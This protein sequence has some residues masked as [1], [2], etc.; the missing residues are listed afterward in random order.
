MNSECLIQTKKKDL[1]TYYSVQVFVNMRTLFIC[2]TSVS[3]IFHITE[4]FYHRSIGNKNYN[5]YKLF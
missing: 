4:V 5:I 3:I 2:R 1:N